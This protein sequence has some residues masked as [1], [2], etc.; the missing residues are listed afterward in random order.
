MGL[1]N[2]QKETG[3]LTLSSGGPANLRDEVIQTPCHT[4]P[5]LTWPHPDWPALP[6][7]FHVQ[8]ALGLL[9]YW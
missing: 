6:V 5:S 8:Q 9:H 1:V 7:T 2:E 3:L 4:V